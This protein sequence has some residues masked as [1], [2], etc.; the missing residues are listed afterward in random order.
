[1]DGEETIEETTNSVRMEGLTLPVSDLERSLAFYR[2]L[3]GFEVE[4]RNGSTI[5]LLRIGE[6]TLGLLHAKVPGPTEQRKNVHVELTTDDLDGLY[7][8]LKGR[9]AEFYEPPRDKSWERSMSLL[10]PDGYRIEF[11]HGRRGRNRTD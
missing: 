6:G 9:G 11:A 1:M 8:D 4:Y 5:A 3:L 7:E 10:D 2:N